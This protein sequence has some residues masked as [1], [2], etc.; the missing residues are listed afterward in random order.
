[1]YLIWIGLIHNT[2]VEET[3][4]LRHCENFDTSLSIFL[5]PVKNGWGCTFVKMNEEGW[6]FELSM[7]LRNLTRAILLPFRRNQLSVVGNLHKVME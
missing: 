2:K 7:S 5:S 6:K 1:M 4:F 3:I